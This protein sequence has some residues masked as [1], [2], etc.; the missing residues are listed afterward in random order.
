MTQKEFWELVDW[1]NNNRDLIPE[2]IQE[3]IQKI[4]EQV[5][6]VYSCRV[7]RS[8]GHSSVNYEKAVNALRNL[9]EKWQLP[10]PEIK[11]VK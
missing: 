1:V 8:A 3:E 5:G 4:L 7:A 6:T 11:A 2:N 10:L 9:L